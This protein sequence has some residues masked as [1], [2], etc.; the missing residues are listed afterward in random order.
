MKLALTNAGAA[1]EGGEQLKELVMSCLQNLSSV[2]L[3]RRYLVECLW[4]RPFQ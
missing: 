2:R 3:D 1:F 4:D